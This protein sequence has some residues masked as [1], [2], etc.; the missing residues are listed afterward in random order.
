MPTGG[1][2]RPRAGR[3]IGAGAGQD[4][5]DQLLAE[6]LG[7]GRQ[8][9]VD[10]RFRVARPVR[11]QSD[12]VVGDLDVAIGGHDEYGP[13]REPLVLGHGPHRQRAVA[14]E[15][16]A[17]PTRATRIEVLRDDQWG[18]KRPGSVET[19]VDSASIPPAD[20]PTTT[21]CENDSVSWSILPRHAHP[22]PLPDP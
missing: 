2:D 12:L 4:H 15:N 14:A 7:G 10:R 6:L 1:V 3:A 17:K 13:G 19:S 8:Q 11:R 18:R 16:F 21:S 9:Q 5:R 20:E 22:G